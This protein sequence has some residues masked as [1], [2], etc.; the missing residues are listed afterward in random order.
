MAFT[1]HSFSLN[2]EILGGVFLLVKC[3]DSSYILD[4]FG[5]SDGQIYQGQ[6]QELPQPTAWKACDGATTQRSRTNTTSMIPNLYAQE[7]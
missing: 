5:F 6:H 4:A 3:E 1:Y 2:G 7:S